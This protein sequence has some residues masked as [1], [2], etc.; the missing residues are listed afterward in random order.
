ML[1]VISTSQIRQKMQDFVLQNSRKCLSQGSNEKFI[2]FFS[3]NSFALKITHEN[4]AHIFCTMFSEHLNL[5]TL[6][7][8]SYLFSFLFFSGKILESIIE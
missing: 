7:I 6:A 5:G 3:Q 2:V 4:K 8:A 1:C